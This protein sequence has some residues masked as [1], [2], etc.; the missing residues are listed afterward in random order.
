MFVW[1]W[2]K[3]TAP[4]RILIT[5][6]TFVN[7]YHDSLYIR[8]SAANTRNRTRTRH[9]LRRRRS[10]IATALYWKCRELRHSNEYICDLWPTVCHVGCAIPLMQLVKLYRRIKFSRYTA[11]YV[12]SARN[13]SMQHSWSWLNEYQSSMRYVSTTQTWTRTQVATRFILLILFIR[14]LFIFK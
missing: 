10:W 3:K 11:T 2:T 8:T 6:I 7:R 1:T 14:S 12:D 4:E 9:T 5:L 13:R